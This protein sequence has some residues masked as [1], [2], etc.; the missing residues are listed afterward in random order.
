MATEIL[1]NGDLTFGDGTTLS[2]N[3]IPWSTIASHPT[4]L[5]QYT[6]NLG[7][8]GGFLTSAS[9]PSTV[10]NWPYGIPG[11][12]FGDVHFQFTWNGSTVGLQWNNC[13]CYC[14]C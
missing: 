12:Q 11:N 1:G 4:A 13:N 8:Y 9:F 5:S 3:I 7:N 10:Y 14:N 6:N 2:S